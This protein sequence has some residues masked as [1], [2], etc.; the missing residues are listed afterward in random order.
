VQQLRELA[1]D[2]GAWFNPS[3]SNSHQHF[4]GSILNGQEKRPSSTAFHSTKYVLAPRESPLGIQCF[5]H[6]YKW[7][8]NET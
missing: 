2:V 6:F 1:D 4:S 8:Q 7:K 5:H 3:T